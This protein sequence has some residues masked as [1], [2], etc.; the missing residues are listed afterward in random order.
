[1]KSFF[2]ILKAKSRCLISYL[3]FNVPKWGLDAFVLGTYHMYV[4]AAASIREFQGSPF[5]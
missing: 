5:V 3:N 2:Y 4:G 1:M